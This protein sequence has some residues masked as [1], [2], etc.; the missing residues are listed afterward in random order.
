M[1]W[2][3]G[4]PAWY[5][6]TTSRGRP[7]SEIGILQG[8]YLAIYVGPPCAYWRSGADLACRPEDRGS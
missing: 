6:R 1:M 3:T 7:M 8:T 4:S 2:R 5:A